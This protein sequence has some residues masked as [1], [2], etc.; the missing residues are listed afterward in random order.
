MEES[1]VN[2]LCP[3]GT[4]KQQRVYTRNL[5][6]SQPRSRRMPAETGQF[7]TNEGI[8]PVVKDKSARRNRQ[9][10]GITQAG[11]PGLTLPEEKLNLEK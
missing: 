11:T 7:W 1:S 6:Y 3:D 8:E 5:Y 9:R 4:K 10:A 2:M